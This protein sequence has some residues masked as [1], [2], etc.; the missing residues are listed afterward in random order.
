MRIASALYRANASAL[1]TGL[2]A[3]AS[4]NTP[5]SARDTPLLHGRG[6]FVLGS[7]RALAR[8]NTPLW[9]QRGGL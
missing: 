3:R 2:Q 5:L 9:T 8:A 1:P 4:A 7:L 6:S